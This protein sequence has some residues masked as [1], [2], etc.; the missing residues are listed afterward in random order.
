MALDENAKAAN[1]VGSLQQYVNDTL[2]DVLNSSRSSIDYGGGLPFDDESL[3][4]W[5]QFRVMAP[6]RPMRLMGPFAARAGSD[7]DARG[8]E[9]LWVLN[10]NCFVRIQQKA[11]PG[12]SNL[13]IWTLR[14]T[15]INYLMPGTRIVV[16]DYSDPTQS[17]GETL[18]YLFVD[19][20]MEDRALYDPARTELLQHNLVFGLRWTETWVP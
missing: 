20:I 1:V 4:Q 7:V 10:V 6:V 9:L 19:E 3:D 18:G 11:N 17:G 16:K 5:V 15:V 2:S 12:F 8:Q 14:D 13:A